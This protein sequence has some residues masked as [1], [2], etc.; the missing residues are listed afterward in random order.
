MGMSASQARLLSLTA[1][2]S[3]LELQAQS[4]S[5]SKIRLADESAEAS[6]E[7]SAA[8]D[9]TIFK[10][11]NGSNGTF[12]DA[13][14]SNV[15]TYRGYDMNSTKSRY[16]SVTDVSGKLVMTAADASALGI[17]VAANGTVTYN[18][19]TIMASVGASAADTTTP[20]YKYYQS[21]INT[22]STKGA[23]IIQAPQ[24]TDPEWLDK[25]VKSGNL[26]LSEFNPT[27][28]ADGSGSFDKVSWTSGDDSVHEADDK[29]TLARAEAK[30]ETTMADIQSK[31]KRFDLQ[32]QQINTEHSAIQ[33]EIETVK[34]VI[35]KNIE[36]SFKIFNA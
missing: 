10:V 17:T 30:H 26:Y 13:N 12:S 21:L 25:Q 34:K 4:I 36:R 1:R 2:M 31:D 33:T 6:R 3:D 28:G 22:L 16:R 9:K 8:L 32:L 20:A 5:N 18:A 23:T 27:G 35:D 7:Y 24:D 15:T 11:E 14:L 19:G 29:T